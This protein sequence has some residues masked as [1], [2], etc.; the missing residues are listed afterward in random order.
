MTRNVLLKRR[1]EDGEKPNVR[2]RSV[3]KKRGSKQRNTGT[4]VIEG[5]VMIL[6]PVR[7]AEDQLL[8]HPYDEG[9]VRGHHP[10]SGL[11]QITTLRN[12]PEKGRGTGGDGIWTLA[13]DTHQRHDDDIGRLHQPPPVPF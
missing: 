12:V 9:V 2:K 13:A 4:Q 8:P 7:L 1:R 5:V 11:R 6:V 3:P 10:V